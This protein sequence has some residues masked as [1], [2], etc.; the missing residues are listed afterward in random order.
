MRKEHTTRERYCN[1][2][3]I[4]PTKIVWSCKKQGVPEQINNSY[5]GKSKEKRRTMYMLD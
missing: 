2:Y 4:L 3:K 1:I 5:N